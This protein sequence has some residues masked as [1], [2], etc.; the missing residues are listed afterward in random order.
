M[1]PSLNLELKRLVT[2]YFHSRS[3]PRAHLA[4]C[5]RINAVVVNRSTQ[6]RGKFYAQRSTWG[7]LNPNRGART[8]PRE[9]SR[10]CPN[11]N[12]D[13]RVGVNCRQGQP[14]RPM[15]DETGSTCVMA[16]T[17]HAWCASERKRILQFDTKMRIYRTRTGKWTLLSKLLALR[18]AAPT[19]AKMTQKLNRWSTLLFRLLSA[20]SLY[21]INSAVKSKSC[22]LGCAKGGEF[23][24]R[25]TIHSRLIGH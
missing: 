22:S 7:E 23:P 20:Q 16:P 6:M 1:S 3:A 11:Q 21:S 2:V 15:F 12:N 18:L 14:G 25:G 4:F 8:N 19:I 10:P 5:R 17:D 24:R 9:A 13:H